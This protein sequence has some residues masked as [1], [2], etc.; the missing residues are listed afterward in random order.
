[1]NHKERRKFIIQKKQFKSKKFGR[2]IDKEKTI[3]KE[4]QVLLSI[5]KIRYSNNQFKL[6]LKTV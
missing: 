2:D 4:N 6:I 3:K 1:M 5:K